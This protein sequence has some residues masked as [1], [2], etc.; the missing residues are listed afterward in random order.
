MNLDI[1]PD[2]NF[3]NANNNCCY[4]TEETFKN[5]IK[6]DNCISV[7]H[8]NSRSL[9]ANFKHINDY[10]RQFTIPFNI[11]AISETWL[12]LDRA[13]DFEMEG[14]DL[15]CI[16]RTNK[17]RGGAAIYID[18]RLKH[19]IVESMTT[20]IEDVCECVT[21]EISMEKKKNIL[22]SCVY[23][24]PDYSVE[25]FKNFMEGMFARTEQKVAYICG[26]FN[27]DLLNPNNNIQ[28][29]EFS[30]AMYSMGLYPTITKPTRITPH[31]ATIIDNIYTNNM[32]NNIVS[33]IF[34]NDI[35][36]HLPVFAIYD[37]NYSMKK[38]VVTKTYRRVRTE[39][40][41]NSFQRDLLLQD[42]RNVYEAEN[43]DIAYEHFLNV[44]IYYYNKNCPIVEYNRNSNTTDK[45]WMTSG[46]VNACRKKNKLY[47]DF[48]KY[49]TSDKEAKYKLYKNKL[50]CIIRKSKKE[51]F[52][53][54]L[55]INKNN[56]KGT[57]N[58]LNK[59][60]RNKTNSNYTDHF[61]ENNR[62]ITNMNEVV[63]GF[64]NFFVGVG[65]N[66]ANEI[67]PPLGG[68]IAQ[69][70]EERN[71]HSIFLQSTNKNE[72]ID[73]VHKFNNKKSKDANDI[74]MALIKKV[75]IALVDPLTYICNL[76][77][78]TGTFPSLMKTAKVI[79]VYKAGDKNLFTNYRPISLL[80][81]FSKILEKI[82][83]ARLDSFIDKH[84]L[85]IDGQY[86][87]RS[88]RSTTM[89]LMELVE[90]VTSSMDN[91]KYALGIFIDLKKAFDTINHDILLQKMERYGIRGVGLNWVKSY[92]EN[93]E[94]YVQIGEYKSASSLI[95]CGVPQGSILGPKLFIL[96][97]NDI[98]KVS[99]ILNF[100]VFADDT[101][102]F[103]A[104][105]NLQQ[106]LEVVSVELGKLK[107]WFDLNKLSLNLKKTK[108]MIFGNKNIPLNTLVELKI[109][110]VKLE[111]VYENLFLGVII[112]HQFSWKPHIKHVRS[113]VARSVG[114][115]GKAKEVLN[116]RSLLTLYHTLIVPYL[117]YCVEVWGNNYVSNL[118]PLVTIQKRAIRI[119]HKVGFYEHTNDLF[120]R[121]N[122][123]KFMDLVEFKTAL[124]MYKVRNKSLPCNILAMFREREGGYNLR[125]DLNL[126]QAS[127][128]T[129]RRA[130]CLSV[131]GVKIWNSLNEDLKHSNNLVQFKIRLKANILAKYSII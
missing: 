22:V 82:F 13:E 41:L 18:S 23:R 86:G 29:D 12:S 119:V 61:I 34:M 128:Q 85:L 79:P 1:D 30:A 90:G 53:K 4:Y 56:I 118:N 77:L 28:I 130:M 49:R 129:T 98:C 93:R 123:L 112:D 17:K 38:E 57:W 124:L 66:L 19:K 47:R 26:D 9:N 14:Y 100:V 76:S 24:A 2:S 43:V 55:E 42:W 114:V 39:E 44:F 7:I 107:L 116:Q 16:N 88:G 37:C 111:R 45:P 3:L 97:I 120:L 72:I 94:Q 125:W 68:C 74:D 78:K 95:T 25:L 113:K 84:N 89:A 117:T 46:L 51:Y 59:I 105:E 20:A 64:N 96:Y 60:I 131:C 65:P 81:Q 126:K 36:D 115:L 70:P 11:I 21:V 75:I 122:T 121:S 104:G 92:I 83:S 50:M 110:N 31:S 63:E 99:N 87:F 52:N 69:F 101:N 10:L 58:I 32:E 103:C 108:F 127:A 71:P 62:T 5:N 27:I 67:N 80:S 40:A 15:K 8:F 109:N 106:L 33:G 73:I 35:S 91:N 48:I 54:L 6:L 102:I